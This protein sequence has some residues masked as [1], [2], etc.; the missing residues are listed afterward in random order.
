MEFPTLST[1]ILVLSLL[2]LSCGDEPTSGTDVESQV[3]PPLAQE[4]LVV[5]EEGNPFPSASLVG[6]SFFKKSHNPLVDSLPIWQSK[7]DSN[8]KFQLPDSLELN[9]LQAYLEDSFTQRSAIHSIG[10]NT[11]EIELT[12]SLTFSI[13][14]ESEFI[15]GGG[16]QD[17]AYFFLKGTPLFLQCSSEPK[18]FNNIPPQVEF[19]HVVNKD[20]DSLSFQLPQNLADS[21]SLRLVEKQLWVGD[22]TPLI[23]DPLNVP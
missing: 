3:Q 20:M 7:L 12:P 5:N 13:V 23:L 10:E 1:S 22:T 4:I 2:F 18:W 6:V 11:S 8:S 21:T 15:Y 9:D 17:S 14:V 16:E 19:L